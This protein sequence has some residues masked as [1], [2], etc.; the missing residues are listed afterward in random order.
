MVLSEKEQ[1]Y[2]RLSKPCDAYTK[3]APSWD[4]YLS[5]YEGGLEFANERNVFKHTRENQEDY[6]DRLARIDN[7]NYC[8]GLVDFF[9]NFIFSEPIERSPGDDDSWYNDFIKD[10]NLKGEPIESF[11]RQVSTHLQ[12]F[13]MCY[14]LVDAPKQNPD[15]VITQADAVEL[16]IR[17][18]WVLVKPHEIIDW[19]RDDFGKLVYVRRCTTNYELADGKKRKIET[20]TEITRESYKI[21]RFEIRSG[22]KPKFLDEET[23]VNA[24]GTIPLLTAFYKRS[25]K[26]PDIG[27]SFLR[28]L[29]YNQRK[30]LNLTSMLDDFLYRQAFNILAKEEDGSLPTMEQN[31]GVIGTANYLSVP[32]GAAFPKY[33]SPPSDPAEIIQNERQRIIGEMFK[34]AAQDTIS[35]MYN[36]E[37]SSGFS[38]AQS[39]SKTV[40]HIATRADT[41]ESFEEELMKLTYKFLGTDVEWAGKIKYKDK[42]EITNL[43]DSLTQL[44]MIVGDL[45]LPSELFVKEELKR[46]VREFDGKLPQDLLK[47]IYSE[48]DKADFTKWQDAVKSVGGKVAANQQKDKSTGT[49]TEIQSE[50]RVDEVSSTN[51]LKTA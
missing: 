39:F 41:L 21:T 5:A 19:L 29:A 8:E 20:F 35:E 10:V 16:N 33:I 18:Y 26:D 24:L 51:K 31:E 37:K 50:A 9:T 12:V 43:T 27:L 36:G 32:K 17:P 45:A 48:I 28:D 47:Q 38:Q 3:M 6:K 46:I 23:I 7:L 11:M 22:E 14:V 13:G 44:M 49:M 40:P 15:T 30:I 34:R 42:Y 4:F 25:I 1:L 2:K